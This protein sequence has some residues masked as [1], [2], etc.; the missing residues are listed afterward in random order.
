[1][2]KDIYNVDLLSDE[3][4]AKIIKILNKLQHEIE[5]TSQFVNE[6]KRIQ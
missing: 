6:L 1:M 2:I 4:I 5:G 3:H